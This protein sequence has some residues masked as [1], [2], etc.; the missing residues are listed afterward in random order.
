MLRHQLGAALRLRLDEVLRLRLDAVRLPAAGRAA[1]PDLRMD[2]LLSLVEGR[3]AYPDLLGDGL[4]FLVAGM[5]VYPDFRMELVSSPAAPPDEAGS[6]QQAELALFWE[7]D[8]AWAG[9]DDLLDWSVGRGEQNPATGPGVRLVCH[10]ERKQT[11]GQLRLKCL[12]SPA[13]G[14]GKPMAAVWSVGLMVPLGQAVPV[15]LGPASQDVFAPVPE[16][17]AAPVERQPCRDAW[18]GSYRLLVP[19][20]DPTVSLPMLPV[21]LLW[22]SCDFLLPTPN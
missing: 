10:C 1:Y 6:C 13:A 9:Q 14:Q 3:A 4:P 19:A 5:G 11:C 2:E 17:V 18:L 16:L 12:F 22:C 8:R 21:N 20:P 7:P 15:W